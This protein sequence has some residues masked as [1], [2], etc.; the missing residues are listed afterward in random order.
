MRAIILAVERSR[1][2]RRKPKAKGP[3]RSFG[4][5][6]VYRVAP[7]ER[8]S[9]VRS[10]LDWAEAERIA[11]ARRDRAPDSEIEAGVNYLARVKLA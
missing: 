6:K 9:I 8:P 5:W 3:P 4:P 7:G 1:S 2:S 10:G 11:G